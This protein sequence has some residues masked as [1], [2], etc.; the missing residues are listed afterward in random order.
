[1]E[2]PVCRSSG[3]RC[4]LCT[5]RESQDKRRTAKS[6][7]NNTSGPPITSHGKNLLSNAVVHV[8]EC[9]RANLALYKVLQLDGQRLKLI[10]DQG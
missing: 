10:C 4:V 3:V 9:R 5:W 7:L 8:R 2:L 6:Y 1:M